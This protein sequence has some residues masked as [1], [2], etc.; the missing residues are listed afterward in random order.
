[1]TDPNQKSSFDLASLRQRLATGKS[2][3]TWR[4]LNELAE[5][6][7]FLDF[8]EEEFPRPGSLA[9][10]L[11]RRDFLK[12]LA[13]PLALAGL[14][15]CFPQPPEKIMP[16]VEAPE[17]II[18]GR[19]LFFA[20]AFELEGYAQGLLVESHMGRPTK[21]EG[22]PQHPASLGAADVFAQASILTLYDPD[23]AQVVSSRG[24]IRTWDAF[25]AA[26]TRAMEAQRGSEGA[27]LRILT[28]TVTSPTLASQIQAL[29]EQFP[30][31]RWHQYE[32]AGRDNVRLGAL[33]AFGEPVETIYRFDRA[34]VILSLDDNFVYREPGKLRYLRDF[35]ARRQVGAVGAEMN[36]L[37]VV[38]STMTSL[39]GFADH[40][41]PLQAGQIESFAREVARRLGLEVPPGPTIAGAPEGWVDALVA[42]LQANEGSS[43]ILAGQQQPPAV[44]ALVHALNA[45]LGNVGQT[46]IYTDPVEANPV[47]Q[48]VSLRELAADLEAGRVEVLIT[49]EGNPVF[50]APVDFNFPEQYLK[51]GL[52]V[53]L[54]LYE[55]ET[56][57]LSHWHIPALHYLEGWGD[58]RAYDGTT[59][60]IQPLI[61]PLYGGRSAYELLGVL[62]GDFGQDSYEIVRGFWQSLLFPEVET[63]GESATA[64]PGAEGAPAGE[65]AAPTAEAPTPSGAEAPT[66]TGAAATPAATAGA[67]QATGGTGEAGDPAVAFE[68]FW[69]NALELGFLPDTAAAEKTAAPDPAL[70]A[71]L[72]P[73]PQAASPGPEV[74]EIVFE[75]DTSIWDGRF[76]NNAWLQELPR[77]VTKLSW[78]NAALI[79]PATAERLDL[80]NGE[81]VELVFDGR[82]LRA[83]IWILPGQPDNSVTVQLGYGRRRGGRVLEGAGFNAY[84][85]RTAAFPWFSYGLEIRKTGD[86]Y[87]L[88]STQDH[89]S[90]DERDLVK[91]GT[92]EQYRENP[93]F[94]RESGHGLEPEDPQHPPSLF[95]EWE[96][97]GNAWGM[98]INLGTCIGCNACVLACQAENNI[99]VVGKDQVENGREMYWL[100]LDAYYQGGLENPDV[101]FQPRLCMHCEKAPC[102]PVCPVAATVHDSEGLN[103][104]VY[105]RCVG[106]RYCSNNC[107]YKVRRFNFFQYS[108]QDIIPLKM[109]QNPDVTVRTRGVIEKCSYC[110]QRINAARIDAKTANRPIRDGEVVTACQQACPTQAIV[111]GNINDE[112]S[113]VQQLKEQPLNYALLAELGTQPRTTYLAKL[114]NPNP[115]IQGEQE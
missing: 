71:N 65:G 51:A 10:D 58:A 26:I 103:N 106:T 25:Q 112:N 102:E 90:M 27:G 54:G 8:L 11:S 63:A 49:L 33:A 35:S 87:K 79:S 16:Y 82:S 80:A 6:E 84:A 85:I 101:L 48:V 69:R 53:Y 5:N 98:A 114:T 107:P 44:H 18:P 73:T 12:L 3:E 92:L 68:R 1:M 38:E 7:E 52:S 17:A 62:L 75:P 109:L 60:I 86:R 9:K 66:P 93:N 115:A 42:D 56:A 72:P 37:Y 108:E 46:V 14:T 36:R 50:T 76:A 19:P 57:A 113:Q 61:E 21:V 45:A 110:V 70:L 20:T 64:A 77:P 4:S 104:M 47:E 32:P 78:D 2:K 81:V 34:D 67:G 55:D 94:L 100:H 83:P 41:L 89:F 28:G 99:P 40:R 96:Y 97:E 43:L 24:E 74:L 23:R 111:F 13:A 105:N 91:V 29:L 95:P 88:V 30:Q 22:N 15:A 59:S 39:G 31:A